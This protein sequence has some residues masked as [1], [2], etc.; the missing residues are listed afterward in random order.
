MPTWYTCINVRIILNIIFNWFIYIINYLI[1]LLFLRH[2][3]HVRVPADKLIMPRNIYLNSTILDR[4]IHVSMWVYKTLIFRI[5][6]R[7]CN[8]TCQYMVDT[9][10]HLCPQFTWIN[11]KLTI[12][13]WTVYNLQPTSS[14]ELYEDCK[15]I[16]CFYI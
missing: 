13:I 14:T 6:T 10:H 12:F 1:S 15:I 16:R 2:F 9:L 11:L 8:K 3:S 7:V 5:H 4:C